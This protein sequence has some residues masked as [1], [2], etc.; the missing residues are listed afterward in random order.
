M[1]VG[2]EDRLNWIM[3]RIQ[4]EP[5]PQVTG[6]LPHQWRTYKNELR[7]VVC[8]TKGQPPVE[9][10]PRFITACPREC[11]PKVRASQDQD[12]D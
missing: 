1:M 12:Q 9:S 2:W 10:F 3:T 4:V 8:G 7:C 5:M 6:T 11:A